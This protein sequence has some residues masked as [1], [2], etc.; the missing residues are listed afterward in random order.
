L[1]SS[2]GVKSAVAGDTHPLVVID[3]GVVAGQVGPFVSGSWVAALAALALLRLAA[4][5]RYAQMQCFVS[6]VVAAPGWASFAAL[7]AW[8][9]RPRWYS[10]ATHDVFDL[11]SA[12][13]VFLDFS[14]GH[15]LFDI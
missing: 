4:L 13:N 11:E 6:G 1:R 8:S 5:C 12:P 10:V 14:A 2:G 9:S 3:V 15:A 7:V